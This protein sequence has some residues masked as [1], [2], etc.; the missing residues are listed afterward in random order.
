MGAPGGLYGG[1]FN[2]GSQFGESGKWQF[3]S[4]TGR[5]EWVG[6]SQTAFSASAPM[7]A[8]SSFGRVNSAYWNQQRN[9]TT[10]AQR[11]SVERTI[12]V[13]DNPSLFNWRNAAIAGLTPGS[14]QAAAMGQRMQTKGLAA[15]GRQAPGYWSRLMD[16]VTQYE[17]ASNQ[18][19]VT[20]SDAAFLGGF[21]QGG[22]LQAAGSAYGNY[23]NQDNTGYQWQEAGVKPG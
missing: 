3:N 4:Q 14:A 9:R 12:P 7:G 13:P 20:S 17:G 11:S 10:E 5:Y 22:G 2:Y 16:L 23:S 21:L 15:M 8:N 18:I 1:A 6:P 19:P